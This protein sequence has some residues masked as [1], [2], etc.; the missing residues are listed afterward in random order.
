VKSTE[1]HWEGHPCDLPSRLNL[2]HEGL[3]WACSCGRRWRLDQIEYHE[4]GPTEN[5]WT[6]LMSSAPITDQEL[7][8]LLEESDGPS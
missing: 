7:M 4:D 3:V 6:E 5:Y 8:S 1:G 2:V